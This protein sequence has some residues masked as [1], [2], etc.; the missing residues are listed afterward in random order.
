MKNQILSPSVRKEIEARQCSQSAR[1]IVKSA[2]T[3]LNT[4]FNIV[5]ACLI[6]ACVVVVVVCVVLSPSNSY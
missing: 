1:N 6:T 3:G 5:I 4:T 2:E